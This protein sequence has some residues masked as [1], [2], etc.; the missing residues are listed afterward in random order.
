MVIEG[1]IIVVFLIIGFVLVSVFIFTILTLMFC[2][3]LG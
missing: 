1:V 2:A 3:L